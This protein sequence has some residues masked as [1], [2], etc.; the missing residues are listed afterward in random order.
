MNNKKSKL[1]MCQ[2]I[3]ICL[4][5]MSACRNGDTN[6]NIKA[7]NNEKIINEKKD[8]KNSKK[9]SITDDGFESKSGEADLKNIEFSKAFAKLTKKTSDSFDLSIEITRAEEIIFDKESKEIFVQVDVVKEGETNDF[10][11]KLDFNNKEKSYKKVPLEDNKIPA[12]FR[13]LV[14]N[15]SKLISE[16]EKELLLEGDNLIVSL[17]VYN[18]SGELM[19]VA[20]VFLD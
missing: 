19:N 9:S 3:V 10:S 12:S 8:E 13:F 2:L 7:N 4:L 6:K 16:K 14:K 17:K 11:Y 15:D 18:P 1:F 20:N 5:I